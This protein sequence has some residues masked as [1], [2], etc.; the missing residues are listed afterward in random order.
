MD[1]I[2]KN[3]RTRIIEEARKLFFEYSYSTVLM[4]DIAQN[5]GMSKKTLYQYFNGKEE[6]LNE[7][8]KDF[9]REMQQGTDEIMSDASLSFPQKLTKLFSF[10]G[11]KLH[12]LHP[13]FLSDIKKNVPA[14]WS[15]IQEHKRNAAFLR[16]NRV[17]DE[18]VQQGFIQE[19]IARSAY[20]YHR[21]CGL[22]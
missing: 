15:L 9:E 16:F 22:P 18:G 3:P 10:I 20:E 11:V 17:L 14:S 19:E 1:Q 7:I 2:Q 6:L 4:A 21:P 8:I 5:L 12:V 13:A